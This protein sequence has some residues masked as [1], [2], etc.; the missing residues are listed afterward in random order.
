MIWFFAGVLAGFGIGAI[1]MALAYAAS[2]ADD[3]MEML[4]QRCGKEKKNKD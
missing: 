2:Q 1:A 3:D 4:Y